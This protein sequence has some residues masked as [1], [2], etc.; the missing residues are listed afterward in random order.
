MLSR[1]SNTIKA[2]N[3]FFKFDILFILSGPEP[4]RTIFEKIILKQLEKNKHLKTLIVRGITEVDEIK[5]N[6]ENIKMINHL[7]SEKLA[8]AIKESEIIICRP[9]YSSIMDVAAMGKKAIFVPTPGQTEQEYLGKY[10]KR[11]NIFYSISQKNFNIL[12]SIE[13]SKSYSGIMIESNFQ[14]LNERIEQLLK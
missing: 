3:N 12:N 13:N 7:E 6:S 1:F 9:G 10:F 5:N 4:Q 14:K 2:S 8:N 11:E